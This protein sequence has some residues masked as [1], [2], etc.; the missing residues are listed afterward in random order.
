LLFGGLSRQPMGKLYC[1]LV[2]FSSRA[3]YPILLILCFLC[4]WRDCLY[5][6]ACERQTDNQFRQP[7][8]T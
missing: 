4:P 7:G 8:H 6:I 5:C 1:P 2:D 3:D